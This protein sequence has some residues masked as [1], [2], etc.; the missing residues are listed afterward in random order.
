MLNR[1]LRAARLDRTLYDELRDDPAATLQ[2]LAIVVLAG[3]AYSISRTALPVADADLQQAQVLLWG[4]SSAIVGWA[5]LSLLAYWGGSSLLG[6]ENLTYPQMLRTTGFASAPA[7]LLL[8][9]ILSPEVGIV[10]IIVV[11]IWLVVSMMV[12]LRQTLRITLLVS[13]WVTTLGLFLALNILDLF[14]RPLGI[15]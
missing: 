12:A 4:V 3:I 6:R 11:F 14:A 15:S 9:G 8:L 10:V 2:A 1:I 13:F 5:I 7:I